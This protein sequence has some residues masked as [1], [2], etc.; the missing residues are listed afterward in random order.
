MKNEELEESSYWMELL[1]DAEIVRSEDLYPTV[2]ECSE[3]IAIFI[4]IINRAF[5]L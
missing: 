4:T 1:T 3:L 2:Q 5:C